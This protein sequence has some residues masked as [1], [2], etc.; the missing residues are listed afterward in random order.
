MNKILTVILLIVL[1]FSRIITREMNSFTEDEL[2]QI[3]H[4]TTINHII[5]EYLPFTPGIAPGHYVLT[6]PLNKISPNN[7][8]ILSIPGILA[9]VLVFILIPKIMNLLDNTKTQ[10]SWKSIF[11]VRLLYVSDP[12]L[13]Y[14]SIEI[15][16]YSLLP[17][18]WIGAFFLYY[19]IHSLMIKKKKSY[20]K[21]FIYILCC[22][23]LFTWHFY[24]FLMYLSI[25]IYYYFHKPNKGKKFI[26]NSS[27]CIFIFGTI[28]SIPIWLHFSQGTS[29]FQFKTFEYFDWNIFNILNKYLILTS[30][31]TVIMFLLVALFVFFI[32]GQKITVHNVTHL[33]ISIPTLKKSINLIIFLYLFPIFCI[34]MIDFIHPYWF[35]Y[36]QFAWAAIPLYI[37][38]GVLFGN[39]SLT[40]HDQL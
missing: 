25:Y 18:L 30:Y 38:I 24:G 31:G 3:N 14:Q 23:A 6:L 17:L 8:Y 12:I 40:H 36:R 39:S 7:K 28:I 19:K 9:S 33:K 35:L 37:S 22:T 21:S 27:T 4:L 20:I 11:L 5:I 16:P 10:T 26:L 1:L 15:R 13:T 2:F 29:E 34:F 32:F